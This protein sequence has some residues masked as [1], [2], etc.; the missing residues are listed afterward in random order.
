VAGETHTCPDIKA[1]NIMFG[2]EDA[3][4]FEKF[5]QAELEHPTPRKE[6]DG[7]IIYL[8]RDLEMP[9]NLGLPVLCDFGSAVWGEEE[10]E[11]DVQPDVYRSPEVILKIPWSYEI[12]IWNVGCMVGNIA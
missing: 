8:S 11:E 10:H 12:D 9:S 1:G 2:V 3:T 6:N 7:R 5:E 4:V